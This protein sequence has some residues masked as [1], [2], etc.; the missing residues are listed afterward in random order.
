[1]AE[2]RINTTGGLKLYDADNS[3]YAQIVAGTITSNVDAIT[4]GHDT[5]TIADNLSLGSD[6]AILKLGADGDATLTHD[7]TTGLT[8]AATPISIDS[9]GELHLNSTTGDIKL[10]DGGTD[11]IAFD[12]DGTAGEVIM[13]PAVDSD[14][15]VISQYDGTEVI[16]IEDN[17]S[18]GLVGNKLSI[19]NSS[20]D[21][22]IKPL[23]D[24][25]DII[26]QQ[27]DGTV[28]ATVEDNATFNIPASKLAIGGTAVTATAAELNLIDGGTARGTTAI[29]D[30]DGVLINDAGTM[31]MTNVTTL[32]TYMGAELS[33]PVFKATLPN[34]ANINNTTA[35][36]MALG[37]EVLDTGGCYDTTNYRFTPDVEGYYLFIVSGLLY[38]GNAAG[39]Y[40]DISVYKNGNK[41]IAN[42]NSQSGN[43]QLSENLRAVGIIHMNGSSDYAEPY[44]YHQYGTGKDLDNNEDYTYFTGF[45][46]T[47]SV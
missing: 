13:K 31:R 15:L 10:Q 44:I 37:T 45:R 1:M 33:A 14:D 25:K 18:L 40:G 42:R 46:I 34:A 39:E 17:A 30:G 16:R 12:L 4:L 35:T 19:A 6:S 32:K 2:I 24:A 11:Q 41:A 28:V 20:S 47:G 21:V 29:A 8:I 23:T 3:H 36:K 27:Y 26:F 9:T 22:V 43:M 5:V 38:Y 7:G